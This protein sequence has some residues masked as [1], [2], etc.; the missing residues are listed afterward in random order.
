MGEDF[1]SRIPPNTMHIYKT[2]RVMDI[3]PDLAMRY[4]HIFDGLPPIYQTACKIVAVAT[5]AE[6]FRLP[7]SIRW[8]VLADLIEEGVDTT[9]LDVLLDEM[10]GMHI[11][12]RSSNNS[13]MLLSPVRAQNTSRL[14]SSLTESLNWADFFGRPLLMCVVM[15]APRLRSRP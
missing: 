15:S 9:E 10:D 8:A 2:Y 7:V 14:V 12:Q 5:M 4:A 6:F 1:V 3:S 13:V 11:I